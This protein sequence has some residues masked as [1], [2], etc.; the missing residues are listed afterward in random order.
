MII[1]YPLPTI[2]ATIIREGDIAIDIGAA[3]A[4]YTIFLSKLV[5]QKGKVYAFEPDPRNFS[6]LKYR[7]RK[8]K[9]VTIEWKAIGDK[10]SKVKF[11]IDKFMGMSSIYKDATISPLACIEVDMVSLDDYF[12]GF[13]DRDIALVKIDVQGSEPLVFNGMKNLIKKVKVLIFE[14]WPL[15]IKAAG[16][17]PFS[18]I[19]RI[20]NNFELIYIDENFNSFSIIRYN[21]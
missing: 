19:E 18:L 12:K 4:H 20:S 11:Y 1:E 9:N 7:T 16:F 17:E 2:M 10:N 8:L 14:F 3:H 13:R 15:G 5:G 6:I 21:I